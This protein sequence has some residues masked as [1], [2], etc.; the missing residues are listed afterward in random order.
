MARIPLFTLQIIRFN[1]KIQKQDY[2]FISY[3]F[4]LF[5]LTIL[6]AMIIFM[7]LYSHDQ[8]SQIQRNMV[9]I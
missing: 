6:L 7:V 1:N 8:K 3:F 4:G 2:N 5:K 9:S